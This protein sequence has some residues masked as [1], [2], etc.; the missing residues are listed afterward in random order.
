MATLADTALAGAPARALVRPVGLQ[1]VRFP[2]LVGTDLLAR[3][4]TGLADADLVVD[5]GDSIGSGRW[6]RGVATLAALSAAALSLGANLPR[7][8][9]A[10]PPQK[11]EALVAETRAQGIGPLAFG[12]RTAPRAAP[13]PLAQR[14]SETPERPRIELTA[15]VGS[16]GLEGALRRA[17]VGRADLDA[18]FAGL[19]GT[20]N[21]RGVRPGT[22]LELVLGR[23]ETRAV[24]RPLETLSFRAAFETRV[25]AR[26]GADGALQ[27]KPIAIAID[28]TPL[29][30]TGLVGTS[31]ERSARAAGLPASVIADYR[32]Q[33]GHVLD[34][35]RDVGRRDRF[36][37]VVEH[38]R[39]ET[40]ETQMGRLIY[41]GLDG[42]RDVSLMRWGSSGEF[43]RPDGEGVKK[44]LIRTPVA[45]ARLSSGFGMRFHPVL[46]YSR[47]HQGVDF[48]AP[49]GTPIL[50]SARG[51]V[52]FAG[53]GGGYGNVVVLDHGKG[54]RT[55]YA[56]M[57]RIG[58]RNGQ[59]VS[60]GQSIGQ[61]GSTGLSTGPHLHYEVWQNGK[62]VDP[63][64]VKFLGGAAQLGGGDLK[65]F[66]AELARLK[67]LP[68]TGGA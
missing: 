12:S 15:T 32:R 7:L 53:W 60:Q 67:A 59:Q 25:E 5:L 22:V 46:R 58:V 41:A 66:K 28:E 18:L 65:R 55:R 68:A 45:G 42:K 3:T 8:T 43:F 1:P 40:G 47:M 31:L 33:L 30:V 10:V 2:R 56:H 24:P 62:P 9:A 52:V 23:R 54:L 13:T 21:P 20:V 14:L 17:G 29:R 26:R 48:A 6:W 61:V 44:G 34:V 11:A 39:A 16:G 38:R 51:T 64:Q 50:A 35:S 37:M 63:K 49:T 57:H 4:A 19:A 27:V 36:E